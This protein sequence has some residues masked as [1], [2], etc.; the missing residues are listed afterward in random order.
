MS[1]YALV[2]P[3]AVVPMELPITALLVLRF[4]RI[5]LIVADDATDLTH[6]RIIY[7]VARAM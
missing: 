1:P 7:R 4:R 5:R 2:S 6:D 3:Y